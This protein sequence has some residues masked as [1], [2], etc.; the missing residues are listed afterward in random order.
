MKGIFKGSLF[1]VILMTVF[2][3]IVAAAAMLINIP[4]SVFKGILW[5]ILGLCVFVGCLPVAKSGSSGKVL[6]GL[7]SAF[8]TVA[9]V[10]IVVCIAGKQIPQSGSF[11]AFALV[12]MLCG[13]LGS[14]AGARN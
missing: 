5:V 3:C 12:C 7:G 10:F 2:I 6:R 11:Y 1:S 8:F 9:I 14:L 13:L 4:D